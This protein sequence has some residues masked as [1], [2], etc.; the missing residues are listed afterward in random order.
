MGFV[1]QPATSV[2]KSAPK[3]VISVEA[4]SRQLEVGCWLRC[5]LSVPTACIT[6]RLIILNIAV[7]S[8]YRGFWFHGVLVGFFSFHLGFLVSLLFFTNMDETL[9]GKTVTKPCVFIRTSWGSS[10]HITSRWEH[11]SGEA[12]GL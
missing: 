6:W 9:Y 8:R 2:C 3:A 11:C 5:A 7:M 4:V 1:L 12:D 10:E